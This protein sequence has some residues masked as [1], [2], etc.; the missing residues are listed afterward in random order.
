MP[1]CSIVVADSAVTAIGVVWT[2]VAP[3]F[4][5]VTTTDSNTGETASSKSSVARPPKSI[6]RLL[7]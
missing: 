2:S 5:A 6:S 3:V 1:T 4:D 7:D